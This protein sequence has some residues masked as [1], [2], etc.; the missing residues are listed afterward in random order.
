VIDPEQAQL[1]AVLARS[2]MYLHTVPEIVT[3]LAPAVDALTVAAEA[4]GYEQAHRDHQARAGCPYCSPGAPPPLPPR[5]ERRPVM[6]ITDDQ[7]ADATTRCT[8]HPGLPC[9]S[10]DVCDHELDPELPCPAEDQAAP[11]A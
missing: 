4:R 10:C 7:W 9:G 8:C 2:H 1:V 5:P 3:A 11:D 6:S